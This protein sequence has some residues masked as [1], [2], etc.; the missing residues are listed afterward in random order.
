MNASRTT[1]AGP[2]LTVIVPAFNEEPH[3]ERAVAAYER[4]V[5]SVCA[6]YEFIVFDDCSR[7]RTGEIADRLAAA[8]SRIR[9]VHNARNR[10]LGYNVREGVRLAAKS[11]CMFL[12]G[13]GDV[14]EESVRALLAHLGEADILI[15]FVGNPEV[16]PLIRRAISRLFT[17]SV[18]LLFGLRLR[19]YNGCA[20]FRTED[21]RGVRMS[22]DS[23]AFQAEVLVRLLRRGHTFTQLPYRI[24]RTVG[25]E[26][27]RPRNV[28]GVI[29]TLLRLLLDVRQERRGQDSRP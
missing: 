3:L 1:P 29:G 19:Y 7:D 15:P 9:V 11:H 20:V 5:A 26:S 17:G 14:L 13:E 24:A 8:N 16:R 23:H 6:D 12:G 22:T 27:F 2:S 18:N 28:A 21:I 4:A 10:G 25:S